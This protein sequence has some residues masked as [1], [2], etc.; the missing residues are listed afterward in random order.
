MSHQ[1]NWNE[2][3][4]FLHEY[5]SGNLKAKEELIERNAPLVMSI[6]R[7][8][9]GRGYEMDDLFQVGC[10]GLLKSIEKFNLEFN[11]QFST[12][13]VPMILGEIK[14][15]LRDDGLIK[16]S[17]SVKENALKIK[18]AK[19]VFISK[20]HKEPSITEISNLTELNK[21]EILMALESMT[22]I[23]SLYTQTETNGSQGMYLIDK[24]SENGLDPQEEILDKL[25][26]KYALKTLQGRNKKIVF[27]RFFQGK[28]QTE[29][30]NILGI[31]QVQISRMEK[32]IIME[33]KKEMTLSN[34]ISNFF[35][36]KG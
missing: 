3:L 8:F 35:H 1:I 27:F 20:H 26:L 19:E 14:R 4:R 33:L 36:T 18:R 6:A 9:S 34:K 13:A 29:T 17:R 21:E 11:V 2:N 30:A 7:R 25:S 24:V 32:K 15:F 10:I 5:R 31:S 22:P 12:Y 16:I 23:E 28:T